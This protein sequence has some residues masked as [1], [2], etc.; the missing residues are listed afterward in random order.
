LAAAEIERLRAALGSDAVGLQH[1]GSTAVP[2]LAAKPVIDIA[3]GVAQDDPNPAA[4]RALRRL[5]Y[6]A[7]R[8]ASTGRLHYRRGSPRQFTV[9]VVRFGGADWTAYLALRDL[10]RREPDAAAEYGEVK[11]RLVLQGADPATYAAAKATVLE[12]LGIKTRRAT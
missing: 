8:R 12:S 11:R 3:L 1:V 5:G 9:H 6:V 2:G 7:R 10:L 4:M